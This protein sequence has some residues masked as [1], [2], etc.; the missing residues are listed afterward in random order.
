MPSLKYKFIYTKQSR[1][2]YR[3]FFERFHQTDKY[4]F[5]KI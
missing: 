3:I 4:S 2:I 5:P 1:L